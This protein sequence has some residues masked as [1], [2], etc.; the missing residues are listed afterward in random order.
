MKKWNTPSVEELN[1]NETANGFFNLDW[2]SPLN[3]ISEK[4]PV[5][6]VNPQPDPTPTPVEPTDPVDV[7][8]ELSGI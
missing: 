6:P 7:V 1:I 3:I 5:T 4:R 2:E 8:D